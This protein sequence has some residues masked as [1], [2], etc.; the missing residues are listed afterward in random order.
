MNLIPEDVY[1]YHPELAKSLV[2]VSKT[3]SSLSIKSACKS[4]IKDKEIKNYISQY[5]YS[6]L[7]I[8]I[9]FDEDDCHTHIFM[10]ESFIDDDWI[11]FKG[12]TLQIT[13]ISN[14]FT[15]TPKNI[16]EYIKLKRYQN[17]YPDIITIYKIYSNRT[18][19]QKIPNYA[20]ELTKEY[21]NFI[22][23]KLKSTSLYLYLIANNIILNFQTKENIKNSVSCKQL[24][25]NIYTY[26]NNL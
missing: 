2:S 22:I 1:M 26:I 18:S 15:I 20:K 17:I 9:I 19:C 6:K 7:G 11:N 3:L 16:Y 5:N 12:N 13:N 10:D 21:F 24:L 25:D 23:T 8:I 4:F 14:N